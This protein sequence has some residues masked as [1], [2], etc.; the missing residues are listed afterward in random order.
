[1]SLKQINTKRLITDHNATSRQ[2][3]L[4][5]PFRFQP[6]PPPQRNILLAPVGGVS[7]LSLR[8]L[9]LLFL[10]FLTFFFFLFLFCFCHDDI[11]PI[12]DRLMEYLLL[13][14]PFFLTRQLLEITSY[15][16]K[17][18]C[19]PAVLREWPESNRSR[20]WASKRS[21]QLLLPSHRPVL[22]FPHGRSG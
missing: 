13:Q 7:W 17:C 16:A 22:I 21:L 4:S 6:T 18:I 14:A 19:S 12:L 8:I 5:S 3:S 20:L 9:L 15:P 10:L 2:D 1:M 11:D